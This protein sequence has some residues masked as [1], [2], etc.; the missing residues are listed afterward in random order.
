MQVSM[1]CSAY[2]KGIR[3]KA[4]Q[5]IKCEN[6][7]HKRCYGIRESITKLTNFIY[8]RGQGMLDKNLN[9][10]VTLDGDDIK[11]VDRFS[12]LGD[13]LY[14]EEGIQEAVTSTI[15]SDWKKFKDVSCIIYKKGMS[16]KDQENSIQMLC[17]KH[18]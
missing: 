9:E 15:K 16:L 4:I 7:V 18:S 11:T 8:Y 1:F 14:L 12:H 13:V 6:W 2:E 5:C 10:R 17:A 3:R